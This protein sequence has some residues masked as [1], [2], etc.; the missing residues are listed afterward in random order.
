MIDDIVPNLIEKLQRDFDSSIKNNQ[1]L[2]LLKK[3]IDDNTATYL[4]VND[5]SIELGNALSNV[6]AKHIT[7]DNLPDGKMYY[8]IANRVLNTTLNQNYKLISEYA[9][10]VQE[11]LNEKAK[12]H[13][14]T[15]IPEVN[16]DKI[17]GLVN[18]LSHEESVEKAK[19]LLD[20]PIVTFSQSIVDEFVHKNA[21]F[22]YKAGLNPKIIRKESGNCCKW[23]RG[24]V[25]IFDYAAA[26]KDVYRRHGN[27]QCTVEYDPKSGKVKDVWSKLWRKK[28]ND[29]N[30]QKRIDNANI[31]NIKRDLKK[32]N[33]KTA[34][35]RDI[36][37]IGKRVNEQFDVASH[38]GD[39]DK[40]KEI[41]ANFREMG[42]VVPK[43]TW[44]KGTSRVVK[45]QLEE[46]F[47]YYPK[48]WAEIPQKNG[49]Q[50][51]VRKGPRGFFSSNGAV[52]ASG[53]FDTSMPNYKESYLTITTN[54]TRKTTPYHE[55]GHMVGWNNKDVVRIEKEWIEYR[56]AGEEYTRLKDIFPQ[57][58]Y[59][60]DEVVK[61][62]N[63]ISPYIGKKYPNSAEVLTMGLEGIYEPS[64]GF[65]KSADVKNNIY[66]IKTILDDEEMLNLT[67]GLMLKG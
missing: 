26:P 8:N 43:E 53:Y 66:D 35:Y 36:I 18:R 63:F 52:K 67:I 17:D 15:Q 19:W 57:S 62:D 3:K 30:I 9:T 41:F 38:I 13:L 14:E 54:G 22:H 11:Q 10:V 46:A 44:A 7:N 64:S 58:L 47:S 56:T 20:D 5:Y 61:K 49:R 45:K 55:I 16:Q 6:L 39:K 2:N 31:E 42:G 23:C 59:R 60:E 48:E 34:S 27:C 51:Y 21:E 28:E 65:I 12:I 33:L 37:D 50:L 4:D 32:I 40:L 29:E 1:K 24:L 25:G